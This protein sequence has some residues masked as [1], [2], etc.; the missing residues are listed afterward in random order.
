M[1]TRLRPTEQFIPE[2]LQKY[3]RYLFIFSFVL[4]LWT[5]GVAQ[6]ERDL[7]N[8][9]NWSITYPLINLFIYC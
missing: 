3:I 1:P 6:S 9:P 7:E 8:N 5:I 4:S 2:S